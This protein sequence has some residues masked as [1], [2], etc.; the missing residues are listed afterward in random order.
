MRIV[1]SQL[2]AVAKT[3]SSIHTRMAELS[4]SIEVN[5]NN[6][7][8]VSK[9]VRQLRVEIEKLKACIPAYHLECDADARQA[10]FAEL[11]A[12]LVDMKGKAL[13][14]CMQMYNRDFFLDSTTPIFDAALRKFLLDY[15]GDEAAPQWRTT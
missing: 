6:P 5:K 11:K 7:E 2:A 15:F 13:T 14:Y 1:V 10:F 8:A 4:A 3:A 9:I 12:Q